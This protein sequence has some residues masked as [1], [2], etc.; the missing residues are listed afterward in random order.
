[1]TF[2]WGFAHPLAAIEF[3][4]DPMGRVYVWREHVETNKTLQE[5]IR[6]LKEREDPQGYHL[7]LCFGDAADPEAAATISQYFAPCIT[8]PMAKAN[9][10][11]GVDLVKTKLKKYDT[12]VEIDEFGTPGE[13]PHFFLDYSCINTK[14]QF[15]MYRAKDGLDKNSALKE[16][17]TNSVAVKT[18]DDCL[19]AIRYGLMH[20]FELGATHHLADLAELNTPEPV[21]V[22]G[23]GRAETF[24]NARRSY[25]DDL[26][27]FGVFGREDSDVFFSFDG[28]R[29]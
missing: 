17:G 10:R 29:L 1:M 16:S 18:D 20:V 24:F 14:R 5:H 26:G 13:E 6:L 2:D 25:N 8:D 28:K 7:D 15:L 3:Q 23:R 19:D 21:L 12:G 22:G 4:V 27:G 9:W 11:Q